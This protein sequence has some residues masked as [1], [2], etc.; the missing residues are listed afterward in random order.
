MT[1]SVAEHITIKNFDLG[2]IR[3][4]QQ[5]GKRLKDYLKNGG[6]Y[7]AVNVHILTLNNPNLIKSLV[8]IYWN[9]CDNPDDIYAHLLKNMLNQ[10][11]H[12]SHILE[13]YTCVLKADPKLTYCQMIKLKS[14]LTI[15]QSQNSTLIYNF[16]ARIHA[17]WRHFNIVEAIVLPRNFLLDLDIYNLLFKYSSLLDIVNKMRQYPNTISY[18]IK[19][20]QMKTISWSATRIKDY[21]NAVYYGFLS[22]YGCCGKKTQYNWHKIMHELSRLDFDLMCVIKPRD[23]LQIKLLIH[24]IQ[25]GYKRCDNCQANQFIFKLLK[26]YE[27]KLTSLH[28][29]DFGLL[30]DCYRGRFLNDCLK[31]GY[32]TVFDIG[33]DD[34]VNKKLIKD[35]QKLTADLLI[36][37]LCETIQIRDL[38]QIII[39][40]LTHPFSTKILA[41]TPMMNNNQNVNHI[42]LEL[43]TNS[44]HAALMRL[45]KL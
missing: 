19:M 10:D 26:H 9:H 33:N 39:D 1:Q 16:I 6:N 44:R 38:S 36:P 15:L 27:I 4:F 14:T 43:F 34:N 45:L 24:T 8:Q 7:K 3:S 41:I 22:D 40:Y 25:E 12:Y 17:E 35:Y 11:Y 37:I 30:T 23:D 5:G 2:T 20:F 32:H 28:F 42:N 31:H 13:V 21:Y 29:C 18:F